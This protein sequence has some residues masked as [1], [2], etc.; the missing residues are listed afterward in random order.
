[1]TSLRSR[2]CIEDGN[3]KNCWTKC[4]MKRKNEYESKRVHNHGG[5]ELTKEFVYLDRIFERK[6]SLKVQ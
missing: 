1:M 4:L 5:E 6:E 2:Y 3:Y